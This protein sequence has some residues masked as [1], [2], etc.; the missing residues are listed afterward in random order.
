MF[1]RGL[2]MGLEGKT[3]ICGHKCSKTLYMGIPAG[4]ASDSQFPFK[5]G[6]KV[7]IHLEGK[8]LIIEKIAMETP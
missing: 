5:V 6:E 7:R 3:T 8:R 4:I 1:K 2:K